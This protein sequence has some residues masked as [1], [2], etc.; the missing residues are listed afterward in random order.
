MKLRNKETEEIVDVENITSIAPTLKADKNTIQLTVIGA[1]GYRKMYRYKSLIELN[2][3]WE[4]YEEREVVFH[5]TPPL[6]DEDNII[7]IEFN[8]HEEAM[9]AAEKLG[10][11]KRLKD[12]GFKFEGIREDY[13]KF[14]GRH[15]PFR[16]GMRYLHFNKS[17]DDEWMKENWKDLDI[18]FGGE[19]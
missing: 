15:L 5:V 7:L 11:W 3:K 6:H 12:K 1:N 9:R 8:A 19:E 18:C 10:A 4:D 14:S 2:E 13:A 16:D 17:E